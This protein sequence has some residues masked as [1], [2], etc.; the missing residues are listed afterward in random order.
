MSTI[1]L[2][3][4][5]FLQALGATAVSLS[6]AD[7]TNSKPLRGIFPI[8]QSPFTDANKLDL[9][10]LADEVRFLDRARAH[11]CVWP[12]NASEWSSLTESERL[13]GAET[14]LAA[15]KKL[16]PAII[17][18]VQAPTADAAARYATHAQK[19][20][21]DAIIS[22]P[23]AQAGMPELVD[24]YKAIGKAT[25]LPL[26]AQAVGDFS[27]DQ[28]IG[29]YRAVPT[30]RYIKDEAGQPLLRFAQLKEKSG[31]ELMVFS[32]GG[33]NQI[34]EMIR[35]FSGCMPFSA[36]ADIQA[37]VWDLWH[38]G[39]KREAIDLFGKAAI[40]LAEISVYGLEAVKY[41]LCE[42]GVLKTYRIREKKRPTT[43]DEASKRAIAD[44]L[45]LM[46]PYFRT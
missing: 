20:G 12:Q 1:Q 15:G 4:R 43:F 25:D 21:A 39:K 42:R 18:G 27:V 24:Y 29:L 13:A 41:M 31:G 16:R 28:L 34:D 22:L 2:P 17:I 5:R 38:E 8:A 6:A 7:S 32:G 9:D 45:K 14:I 19:H 26:F 35:G 46:K 11:G 44:M 30:L 36:F 37:S 23:L 33:K 40:L 3:R 10:V